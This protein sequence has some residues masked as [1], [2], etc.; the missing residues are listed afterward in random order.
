MHLIRY[1]HGP[2]VPHP[3]VCYLAP[4]MNDDLLAL[5]HI[6]RRAQWNV[7]GEPAKHSRGESFRFDT[8]SMAAIQFRIKIAPQAMNDGVFSGLK[9]QFCVSNQQQGVSDR[10]YSTYYTWVAIVE[11]T[12]TSTETNNYLVLSILT[13]NFGCSNSKHGWVSSIKNM[14]CSLTT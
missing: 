9:D 11:Y 12:T 3:A 2:F 7:Q 14:L 5:I 8:N 10:L 13:S 4:H 6:L 1:A